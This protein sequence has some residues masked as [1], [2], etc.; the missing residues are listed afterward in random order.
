MNLRD[1]RLEVW[2]N[3]PFHF[4]EEFIPSVHIARSDA[5]GC[6][7]LDR[8]RRGRVGRCRRTGGAHLGWTDGC[9]YVGGGLRDVKYILHRAEI[10]AHRNVHVVAIAAHRRRFASWNHVHGVAAPLV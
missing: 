4:D 7:R 1:G 6:A 5:D 3:A 9:E 10:T 8:K 2:R